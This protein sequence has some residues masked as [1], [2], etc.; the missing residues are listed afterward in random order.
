LWATR[1]TFFANGY[2]VC[3][4]GIVVDGAIDLSNGFGPILHQTGLELGKFSTNVHEM[5]SEVRC[6]ILKMLRQMEFFE[7][8]LIVPVKSNDFVEGLELFQEV[9]QI[10]QDASN[11]GLEFTTH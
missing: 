10:V 3:Q 1:T 2:A 7:P 11:V 8:T 9:G 5:A 6:D 4:Q